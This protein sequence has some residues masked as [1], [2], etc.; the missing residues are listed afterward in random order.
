MRWWGDPAA[1]ASACLPLHASPSSPICM[2]SVLAMT[3]L[4]IWPPDPPPLR[5][6]QAP[7]PHCIPRLI[8]ILCGKSP[9]PP[10][11][12]AKDAARDALATIDGRLSGTLVGVLS[13]PSLP[14]SCEGQA[15]R[16]IGEATDKE[17][18]AAMYCWWLPW[19]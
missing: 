18:L 15:Q 12:Q 13:Q 16:L 6:I 4:A 8:P 1:L 5:R 2:L 3:P 17:N 11:P 19:M 7:P 9:P 10:T 14:L